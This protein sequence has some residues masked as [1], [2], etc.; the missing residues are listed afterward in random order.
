MTCDGQPVTDTPCLSPVRV[1]PSSCLSSLETFSPCE[2]SAASWSTADA[3]ETSTPVRTESAF[4][5][6][7]PPVP[8]RLPA[9]ATARQAFALQS[10]RQ[11]E[12][13]GVCFSYLDPSA[14]CEPLLHSS[15]CW[16]LLI[17]EG[18]DSLPTPSPVEGPLVVPSKSGGII[19]QRGAA[20]SYARWTFSFKNKGSSAFP[21]C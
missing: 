16:Q 14:L 18:P 5:S 6:Q 1:G 10:F 15:R 17:P 7:R 4:F 8:A 20:G 2:P 9:S 12:S 11:M 21:K 19:P 13:R 3:P